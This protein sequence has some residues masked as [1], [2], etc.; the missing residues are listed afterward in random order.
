MDS[1]YTLQLQVAQG[2]GVAAQR[3]VLDF[4]DQHGMTL[5]DFFALSLLE[6]QSVGLSEQQAAALI[7]PQTAAA[8]QR[9]ADELARN[10]IQVIHLYDSLYPERLKRVLGKAAPPILATWGNLQLL[11]KPAIGWCGS[12]DASPQGIDFAR[13]T[14]ELAVERGITVVSGAARGI[15]TA[16]HYTALANG[17]TTIVVAPEG[18]LNFRLRAEIK[19]LAAADNTLVISEFQPNARWSAANAITVIIRSLD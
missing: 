16:A 2:V 9:W 10:K 3:A 8:A 19:Q 11:G 5:E 17:G 4:V 7:A 14:V 15:D 12:R 18:I 1:R 13:D 6:W